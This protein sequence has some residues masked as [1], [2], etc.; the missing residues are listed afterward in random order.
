MRTGNEQEKKEVVKRLNLLK[1][2]NSLT[3]NPNEEMKRMKDMRG[4]PE[5]G[6]SL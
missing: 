6:E 3:K 1:N 4:I 2:T 5:G